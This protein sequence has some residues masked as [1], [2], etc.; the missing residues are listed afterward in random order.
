MVSVYSK[1]LQVY[2]AEQFKASVTAGTDSY[3]YFTFGKVGT[4]ANDSAPPQAN[5]SV[6][7]FYDVWKNMVGV[8]RVQGNDIRLAIKRNDWTSNTVYHEY[9]DCGCSLLNNNP[10]VKYFVVTSDWNVY[11]CVS[12]NNG[13]VS[14]SKPTSTV[15]TSSVQTPDYYVWKYMYTLTDEERLRFVTEDYIPVKTLTEDDGSLQWQ[16]QDE[17]QFG[18]IEHVVITSGGSG[19]NPA[20]PPTITI[21][22]DGSGATATATVNATTT[23]IER[24][25]I[26][27][28]G[29]NYTYANVAI[30]PVLANSAVLRAVMSPP[31]GHGKNPSEELGGSNV[32]L[33]IRLRG[34]EENVLDVQNEFRQVSLLKNPKLLDSS[35]YASNLVYSQTT[36]LLMDEG[37]SNYAE[38]E[39]V[40]QGASL[41]SASFRGT[42]A[43]WTPANN[44]LEL[45]DVIGN[46]T[47]DILTGDS[48]KVS[49]YVES[50]IPRD[51]EPFSGSLLYINNIQPIQRAEDQTEDF[52]IV[53]SF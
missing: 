8:K 43:S 17:A 3:V 36:T 6:A 44:R 20:V 32:L 40:Y 25:T 1:N 5:T 15:T 49:R 12:N 26:T 30:T 34:S 24:I 53:I 38:D 16:V 33:N 48:T 29:A 52:K 47:T 39:Y 50:V 42:V 37:I 46:P 41:E 11:K 2:N 7:Y 14:T 28:K 18:S 35:T 4:W 9:D 23:A 31:G 45:I 10:N 51:L 22:G 13:S 27:D 19:Y 21:T